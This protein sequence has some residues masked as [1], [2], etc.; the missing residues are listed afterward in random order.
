MYKKK[1]MLYIRYYPSNKSSINLNRKEI[2]I[3]EEI[4]IKWYN[5]IT[6][7][8]EYVMNDTLIL[9]LSFNIR[10]TILKNKPERIY[11]SKNDINNLKLSNEIINDIYA[12]EGVLYV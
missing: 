11:I 7:T 8:N 2:F 4:F 12:G 6:S 9:E 3:Y 1:N 5:S 10:S